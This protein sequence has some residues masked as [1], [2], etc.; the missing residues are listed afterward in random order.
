MAW[1]T[2]FSRDIAEPLKNYTIAL[3]AKHPH[4]VISCEDAIHLQ[5]LQGL[6]DHLYTLYQESED[7]G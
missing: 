7:D 1:R 4:G 5:I 6:A 3:N 2:M